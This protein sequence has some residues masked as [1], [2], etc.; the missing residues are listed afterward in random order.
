MESGVCFLGLN[1]PA[2]LGEKGV[3]GTLERRPIPPL[4]EQTADGESVGVNPSIRSSGP[5]SHHG[6]I[7]QPLE[8]TLQFALDRPGRGLPLPAGKLAAVKLEFEQEVPVHRGEI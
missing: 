6:S 8:H 3:D 1:H 4:G 2:I 5:V 7:G